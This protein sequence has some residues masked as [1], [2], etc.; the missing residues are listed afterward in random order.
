[1]NKA[2][3]WAE[4]LA[5]GFAAA[6]SLLISICYD[7]M[8]VVGRLHDV[9]F[10]VSVAVAVVCFVA[11]LLRTLPFSPVRYRHSVVRWV[12]LI[13]AIAVVAA[14]VGYALY[15]ANFEKYAAYPLIGLLLLGGTMAYS[16]FRIVNPAGGEVMKE[17]D[18][19]WIDESYA[20]KEMT[21]RAVFAVLSGYC[22]LG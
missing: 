16:I 15:T 3:V 6:L 21:I 22:V 2:I 14:Y 4:L 17:E 1:M 9:Y 7:H 11:C 19:K 18:G 13:D 20:Y 10:H 8:P 5:G 12:N